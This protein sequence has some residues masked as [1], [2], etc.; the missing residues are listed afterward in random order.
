MANPAAHA[1]RLGLGKPVAVVPDVKF[2]TESLS[3]SSSDSSEDE[4]GEGGGPGVG[5]HHRRF[6]PWKMLKW[7]QLSQHLSPGAD[8]H[9]MMLLAAELLLADQQCCQQAP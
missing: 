8:I 5:A 1:E 4:P 2:A 3:E 6:A 7:L 9:A